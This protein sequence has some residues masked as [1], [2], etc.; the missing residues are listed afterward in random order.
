MTT[1]CLT[2]I[3]IYIIYFIKSELRLIEPHGDKEPTA[4]RSLHAMCKW[5]HMGRW[6]V[7]Q[8]RATALFSVSASKATILLPSATTK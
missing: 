1:W 2:Y 6:F 5:K 3:Y 4:Y 8:R 7:Q